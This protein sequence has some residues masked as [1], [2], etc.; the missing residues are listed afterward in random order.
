[1]QYGFVCMTTWAA[2]ACCDYDLVSTWIPADTLVDSREWFITHD[3]T[4][5]NEP[6]LFQECPAVLGKNREYGSSQKWQNMLDNRDFSFLIV[7]EVALEQK[8][9]RCRLRWS[10][11]VGG[12]W[13][14]EDGR[15]GV[16]EIVFFGYGG[17]YRWF[18]L[19]MEK[20]VR[21]IVEMENRSMERTTEFRE[22]HFFGF[23]LLFS[24]FD[25]YV[26]ERGVFVFG[27]GVG[28]EWEKMRARRTINDRKS[29]SFLLFSFLFRHKHISIII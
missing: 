2:A 4:D 15:G 27:R 14:R 28:D 1:M 26:L 8:C 13:K 10:L 18:M 21:P 11:V 20:G 3:N 19:L 16:G 24:C 17:I 6:R 7:T 23:L 12:K 5:Q 22:A 9:K 25:S 29:W